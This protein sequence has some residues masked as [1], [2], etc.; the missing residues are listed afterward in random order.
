MARTR[1]ITAGIIAGGL[2][3]AVPV[4]QAA[5]ATFDASMVAKATEQIKEMKASLAT[6]LEQLTKLK[7]QLGFLNDISDFV[8]DVSDAIGEVANISL[9]IP[10]IQKMAAQIRSDVGCLTPDGLSWGIKFDDLNLASICETSSKYRD[11]LFVNQ[12]KLT[13]LPFNEQEVA[14]RVAS[15]RRN[16]LLADTAIR[17]L[18]QADV[19]IQQADE[20]NSA[21]DSL[22]SDLAGAKTL[23]QR[24]HIQAQAQILQ[25]R[26]MASQNQMMAQMLKLQS[27]AE[28]KAGLSADAVLEIT[29]EGGK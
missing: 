13:S 7:E 26:A 17:G 19:Q 18:A 20:L 15:A 25:A 23:Q 12:S 16:A 4:A 29:G 21:A 22:Q 27:A 8:N 1:L 10:N 9:P 11:A 5:M 3:V 14:R 2:F 6:E 24:A 28:I